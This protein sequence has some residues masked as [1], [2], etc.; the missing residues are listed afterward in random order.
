[1][2]NHI[3]TAKAAYRLCIVNAKKRPTRM[4]ATTSARGANVQR[5]LVAGVMFGWLIFWRRQSGFGA[6]YL[7]N[8][9]PDGCSTFVDEFMHLP[10][11]F[12]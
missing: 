11:D 9:R 12:G 6:L 1:M 3:T 2:V 7:V 4:R 10:V 5:R 8:E